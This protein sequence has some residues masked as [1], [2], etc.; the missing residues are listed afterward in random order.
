MAA[1]GSQGFNQDVAESSQEAGAESPTECGAKTPK[2]EGAESPVSQAFFVLPDGSTRPMSKEEVAHV[3]FHDALVE[4]D[5]QDDLRRWAQHE[6][7]V[8]SEA[9]AQRANASK[10]TGFAR[11]TRADFPRPAVLRASIAEVLTEL[12]TQELAEEMAFIAAA[13]IAV[14]EEGEALRWLLQD[15]LAAGPPGGPSQ[16]PPPLGASRRL[17][18]LEC[19]DRSHA[20]RPAQGQA[21][22][23]QGRSS[24]CSR[25]PRGFG[26]SPQQ[27]RHLRERGRG[28]CCKMTLPAHGQRTLLFS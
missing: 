27:M 9:C 8:R 6:V 10:S 14:G 19:V 12:R 11:D 16:R 17:G 23:G 24:A 28:T 15:V 3:A 20:R 21:S 18:E 25:H 26:M 2:R 22:F 5:K 13:A 1:A 7:A 4:E